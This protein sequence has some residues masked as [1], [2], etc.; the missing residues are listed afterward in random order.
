MDQIWIWTRYRSYS[1]GYKGGKI[2]R[3]EGIKEVLNRDHIKSNDLHRWLDYVGWSEF[4]F[5][6]VADG[7]R[8]PDVWWIKNNNWWKLDIDGKERPYG[9]IS[10][11]NLRKKYYSE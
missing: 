9:A 7:F 1:Q 10:N 4:E 3:E 6:K 5:D 11:S 8:D 2:T